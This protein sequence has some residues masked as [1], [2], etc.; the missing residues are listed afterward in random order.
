MNSSE[1]EKF[2]YIKKL[3]KEYSQALTNMI[4]VAKEKSS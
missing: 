3:N 4:V 1:K 2:D